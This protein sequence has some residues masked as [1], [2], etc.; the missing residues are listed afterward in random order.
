[1]A[2]SHTD[3]TA[4][5]EAEQKLLQS[6]H[7]IQSVAEASPNI[8]YVYDLVECCNV[9]SNRQVGVT[10]GYSP[11]AIQQ[12]GAGFSAAVAHPEDLSRF[13]AYYASFAVAE[14]GGII[15]N[16]YRMRHAD[17]TW[18]WL[19]SRDTVFNRAKDGSPKQ[20]MGTAQDITAQKTY[21]QQIE[22]QIAQV[23]EANAK[24]HALATTDGL[25]GLKNHRAFQ[26]W[27]HVAFEQHR[28]QDRRCPCCFWMWINSSSSMIRSGIPPGMAR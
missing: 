10:L 26:E 1:M 13:A 7:F 24:L 20:I 19:H 16:E 5:R 12:M 22:A 23:N 15:E 9:Y 28:E 11:E 3:I 18:R 14:D 17:G 6:R 2:G 25:T 4:R 8:L 27:L 21:E